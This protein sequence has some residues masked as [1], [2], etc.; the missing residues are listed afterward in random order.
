MFNLKFHADVKKRKFKLEVSTNNSSD[1][2]EDGSIMN[3]IIK[4]L[5]GLSTILGI[6]KYL[7]IPLL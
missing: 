5:I 3:K 7:I 2:L 4:A 6:W 1:C